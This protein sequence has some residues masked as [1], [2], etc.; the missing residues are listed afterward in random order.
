MLILG[1]SGK[2]GVGKTTLA[3]FLCNK[4]D[5]KRVSFAEELRNLA[6]VLFP[7]K[8]DDLSNPK[9]KEAKFRHYDWTPR[10]FMIHLGEFLRFH[11]KSYFLN[12]GIAKCKDQKGKYVIDDVRYINEAEAIRKMGGKIIRVERYE[13]QNPYGKNLDVESETQLDNYQFDYTIKEPANQKLS[14]LMRM[15]DNIY[16]TYVP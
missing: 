3:N 5:F 1:I 10:E 7:L 15:A 12:A 2:R 9:K 13:H 6:Q 16:E 14:D 11:D 8:E 4:Y